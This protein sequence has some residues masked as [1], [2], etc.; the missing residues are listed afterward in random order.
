[1]TRVLRSHARNEDLLSREL[2]INIRLSTCSYQQMA[3]EDPEPWIK[4]PGPYKNLRTESEKV[5]GN[6]ISLFKGQ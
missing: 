5:N 3:M 1:M 2:S 4:I 6:M